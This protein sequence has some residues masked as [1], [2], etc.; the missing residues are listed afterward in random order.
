[1]AEPRPRLFTPA[2][3]VVTAAGFAYFTSIGATLPVLP[4]YINGTLGGGGV[5]IGF[6]VGAFSISAVFLRPFIGRLGD[7]IGRRPI[8]VGGG[9]IAA[10]SIALYGLIHSIW[11]LVFL[12]LITGV[13]EALFFTGATTA[14]QDLS[15]DARRGE[16]ASLFSLSLFGGLAAGPLLGETILG[17]GHFNQV[18][19]FAALIGL[20]TALLSLGYKDVH[21]RLQ[22]LEPAPIIHRGAIAPGLALSMNVTGFA[23]FAAFMPLY[24]IHDLH[25]SGS[26]FVFA[27]YAVVVLVIRLFGARLPDVIGPRRTASAAALFVACGLGTMAL[28]RSSVGLYVATVVFSVGHALAFPALLTLAV[29]SAPPSKRGAAVGTFTAFFDIAYGFGAVPLGAIVALTGNRGAFVAA[30]V[31]ALFGFTI[32]RTVKQLRAPGVR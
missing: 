28:W 19:L 22:N 1:L 13:G 5:A 10:S 6:G 26:R 9:A 2:F 29:Q 20:G 32:L 21:E 4:R 17:K 11:W 3:A 16:A 27:L 24:A 14:V 25:L 7:R 15:P 30:S 23:A 18:W 12:R 31:A 8:M